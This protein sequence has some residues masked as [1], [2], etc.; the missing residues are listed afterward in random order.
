MSTT[1]RDLAVEIDLLRDLAKEVVDRFT[2]NVFSC[3]CNGEA[4]DCKKAL[5]DGRV[6]ERRD[7]VQAIASWLLA[8]AYDREDQ[9]DD[10][11]HAEIKEQAKARWAQ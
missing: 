10:N 5:N 9:Q 11:E 7:A 8:L 2:P 6:W 4:E 1:S 3:A